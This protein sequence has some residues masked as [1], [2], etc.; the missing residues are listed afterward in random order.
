M[1]KV[2]LPSS[3]DSLVLLSQ[4]TCNIGKP[5]SWQFLNLIGKW[6]KKRLLNW[7]FGHNTTQCFSFFQSSWNDSRDLESPPPPP[8]VRGARSFFPYCNYKIASSCRISHRWAPRNVNLIQHY[9]VLG[10]FLRYTVRKVLADFA[11]CDWSLM[12]LMLSSMR[13]KV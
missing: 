1:P 8:P 3:L 12:T 5:S 4:P 9:S 13:R 6:Y 11:V 7:Y 10:H 2:G